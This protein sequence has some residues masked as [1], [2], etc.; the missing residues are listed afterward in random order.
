M[1]WQK[2]GR[3]G[4]KDDLTLLKY[5]RNRT[6][7]LSGKLALREIYLTTYSLVYLKIHLL[8]NPQRREL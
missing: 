6:N 4:G 3:N 8:T 2:D 7:L 1:V 5:C